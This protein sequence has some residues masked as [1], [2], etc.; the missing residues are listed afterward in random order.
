MPQTANLRWDDEV[1]GKQPSGHPN[2][3]SQTAETPQFKNCGQTRNLPAEN[4]NYILEKIIVPYLQSMGVG[5]DESRSQVCTAGFIALTPENCTAVTIQALSS[6]AAN[7]EY[8]VKGGASMFL[9]AG[10]SATIKTNKAD[11]IEIKQSG[12]EGN[13]LYYLIT[14]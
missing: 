1:W 6:N 8:T 3:A 11:D 13:T 7:I 12:G 2:N 4:I 9:E 10:Q 14:I 5:Q